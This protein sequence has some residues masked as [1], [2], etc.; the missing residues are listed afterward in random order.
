[1]QGIFNDNSGAIWG[2][3]EMDTV[4]ISMLSMVGN[5]ATATLAAV[6][7]NLAIAYIA[8]GDNKNSIPIL[9]RAAALRRKQSN[10]TKL[11][12]NAPNEVLQL[13]EEK[14]MLI[15]AKTKKPEKAQKKEKRVPF[16]R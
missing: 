6:L 4:S 3:D 1:M 15:A 8:L 9:L 16:F 5:D 2:G 12:W 14:A 13:A 10:D 7:H 11:Y